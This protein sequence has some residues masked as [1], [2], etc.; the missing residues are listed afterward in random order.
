MSS[1]TSPV[2]LACQAPCRSSRSATTAWSIRAACAPRPR[3]A[4]SI[5]A[6]RIAA[7]GSAFCWPA[8]RC[9]LPWTGPNMPGVVPSG[10][11]DAPAASLM[12]PVMAAPSRLMVS[13][14]AASLT[15]TSNRSGSVTRYIAAKS[16]GRNSA[17]TSGDP[18]SSGSAACRR[19]CPRDRRMD[20]GEP[21]A[22]A[23][24]GPLQRIADQPVLA[25]R[26]RD[27]CPQ[28][29]HVD[30]LGPQVGDRGDG[31]G[32]QPHRPDRDALVERRLQLP[33]RAASGPGGRPGRVAQRAEQDR[34]VA[35]DLLDS[36]SRGRFPCPWP[37]PVAEV[38]LGRLDRHRVRSCLRR[39]RPGGPAGG[40][41]ED[42]DRLGYHLGPDAAAAYHGDPDHACRHG[43]TL[44]AAGVRGRPTWRAAAGGPGRARHS[45]SRST[46]RPE[47]APIDE[48]ISAS[49]PGGSAESTVSTISAWPPRMSRQTCMPAMLMP[50]PPRI[51]PTTPTTPGR[52]V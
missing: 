13:P 5:P 18:A 49:A 31:A 40:C 33:Q 32:E 30:R 37:G 9:A 29:L 15:T 51:W 1:P 4:Q 11:T 48:V 46:V 47:V 16:T 24:R 7:V 41:P 45:P 6:A 8:M 44:L 19:A 10:L 38:E 22:G 42:L 12:P 39:G 23:L 26:A 35:S 25:G 28:H 20:E 2:A 52:S 34:V 36:L 50:R 17:V 43:S 27:R 14:T 3:C 21:T